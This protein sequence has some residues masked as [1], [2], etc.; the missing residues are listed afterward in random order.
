MGN[1]LDIIIV[2]QNINILQALNL[3]LVLNQNI[4]LI[5]VPLS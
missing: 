1:L 3:S 2:K 4:L 5:S